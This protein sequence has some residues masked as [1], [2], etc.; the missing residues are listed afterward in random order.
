[1][2]VANRVTQGT[3]GFGPGNVVVYSSGS[4]SASRTGSDGV[5]SPVGITVDATGTLYV[6]N[7]DQNNVQEYRSGLSHPFQTITQSMN[8]PNAV[9]VDEKGDLQV[10]DNGSSVIVEF[11]PGATNPSKR[12]IRKGLFGPA[13]TAYWP[14]LS[15]QGKRKP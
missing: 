12:E 13:G 11:A 15:P 2:Y 6:T 4:T 3:T 10:T 1:M 9:T 7:I 5:V 8:G 14:P